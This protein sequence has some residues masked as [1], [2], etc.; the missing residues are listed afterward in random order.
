MAPVSIRWPNRAGAPRPPTAVPTV[1]QPVLQRESGLE[2]SAKPLPK[3]RL[4]VT[5]APV[6]TRRHPVVAATKRTGHMWWVV[7]IGIVLAVGIVLAIVL[8]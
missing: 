3:T 5:P 2:P 4:G 1:R 8:A 6:M 7:A